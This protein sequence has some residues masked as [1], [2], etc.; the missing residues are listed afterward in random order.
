MKKLI[1]AVLCAGIVLASCHKNDVNTTPTCSY[2]SCVI[3]APASEVD[4]LES[5]LS[6]AGITTA[7]KHCSGMYYSIGDP[8]IGV[9][10]NAC[11]FVSMNYKLFLTTNTT[12]AV[13]STAPGVPFNATLATLVTGVVDGVLQIRKG[14]KIT[15]Y[16]PP[17]LG[18]GAVVNG[19]IPANSIL[20]FSVELVDVQ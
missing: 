14:G 16:I 17:S 6:R 19:K 12:T 9:A 3:K 5:Y 20:I 10:P 13:D 18:Y 4:T 11:S 15:L 7:T 8:G 1:V 2:D